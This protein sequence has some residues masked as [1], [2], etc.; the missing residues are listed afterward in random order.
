[1]T[2][3]HLRTAQD[4]LHAALHRL[5]AAFRSAA[6]HPDELLHRVRL[7]GLSG[8][9]RWYDPHWPGHLY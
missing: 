4:R 9:D 1:M 8:P 7:L 6:V 2:D 5:T 3:P